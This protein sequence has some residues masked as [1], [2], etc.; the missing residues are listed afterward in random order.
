MSEDADRRFDLYR[1]YL[2]TAESVSDRRAA[3][4]TWMLSVNVALAGFYG[5]A[6]ALPEAGRELSLLAIPLAGLI[7]ALA[8]AGLLTSYRKLNAAKFAVLL[9]LER[10]L[11]FSPFTDEQAAY[12]QARRRPLSRVEKAVPLAF[13]ALHGA[14]AAAHLFT[15]FADRAAAA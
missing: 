10:D 8:W 9:A 1:L 3:A 2:A 12:R 14:L 11:P 7:V 15:A 13:A 5:Y 6:A 4:N